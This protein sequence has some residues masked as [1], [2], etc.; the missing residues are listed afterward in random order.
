MADKLTPFRRPS[1]FQLEAM[2]LVA[3][4]DVWSKYQTILPVRSVARVSTV[5]I[6][7]PTPTWKT[8]SRDGPVPPAGAFSNLNV[9]KVKFAGSGPVLN[10][11]GAEVVPSFRTCLMRYGVS[12]RMPATRTLV[13]SPGTMGCSAV[14]LQGWSEPSGRNSTCIEP[15]GEG[16]ALY[17]ATRGLDVG[18][19]TAL[20][21]T[22]RESAV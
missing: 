4:A 5:P 18:L 10:V 20:D 9:G 17:R 6:G 15:P 7:P 16:G 22:T 13:L 12:G 14:E 3:G 11:S 2:R 19:T 8:T 1:D 21:P